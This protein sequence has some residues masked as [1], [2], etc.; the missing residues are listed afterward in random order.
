MYDVRSYKILDGQAL[1][2]YISCTFYVRTKGF[3]DLKEPLSSEPVH[4][5]FVEP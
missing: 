2:N 1:S 3:R 5:N 4:T